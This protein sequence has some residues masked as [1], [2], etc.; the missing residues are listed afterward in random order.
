VVE[1]LALEGDAVISIQA[2]KEGKTAQEILPALLKAEK[3]GRAKAL[4][5]LQVAA[6][7]PV[8]QEHQ[9]ASFT[10]S[11]TSLPIEKQAMKEWDDS[12]TGPKLKA[13]F[14]NSFS[15]YLAYRQ[16]EAQG[17]TQR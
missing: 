6:A 3:E 9:V 10:E 17:Q 12:Q 8:G 16:A 5:D 15:T 1:I 11:A 4:A 7:P 14:N 2:I 13:E